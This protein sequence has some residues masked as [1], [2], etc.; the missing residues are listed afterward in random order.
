MEEIE[1]EKTIKAGK[2][3]LADGEAKQKKAVTFQKQDMT[4]ADYVIDVDTQ[5]TF[6]TN[7]KFY[8]NDAPRV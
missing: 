5:I 4:V 8:K 2:S 7:C 1:H 6:I 3:L